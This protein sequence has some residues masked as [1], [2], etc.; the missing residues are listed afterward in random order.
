MV[1]NGAPTQSAV[2][3]L[4]I[5]EIQENSRKFKKFSILKLSLRLIDAVRTYSTILSARVYDQPVSGRTRV[6]YMV[7]V[8]LDFL[9]SLAPCNE[10]NAHKQLQS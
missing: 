6:Q 9:V 8:Y 5:Q 3:I 7:I 2:Q 1:C 4:R 10:C